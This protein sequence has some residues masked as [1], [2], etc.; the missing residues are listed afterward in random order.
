[1]NPDPPTP[2]RYH[3]QRIL[4]QVGD[5]G[6]QRLRASRVL[7]V[8]CG[9]LGSTVAELLVRG[10]I[11]NLRIVDRDLVELTNLQR[12]LL[13]SERDAREETPKAV[14]AARRLAEINSDVRVEPI[15]ADCNAHNV[16]QLAAW[17]DRPVDLILDGA[18]NVATRYLLNDLAV[19]EKIPWVYGACVGTAGRVMPIWPGQTPCL[20][21]IFPHPPAAH[22]LP[23]CDTSGVLGPA[24]AVVGAWQAAAAMRMLIAQ[25]PIGA[26]MLALDPWHG[27]ARPFAANQ[28]PQPDCLCCGQKN[29]DFLSPSSAEL[30]SSL[31]GRNAVQVQK[32]RQ[33]TFDLDRLSE[34]LQSAGKIERSPW[35]VRCALRDPGTIR[36]T[37]FPDGRLL[38]HGTTDPDRAKSIYARFIGS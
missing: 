19:R 10:G 27:Q 26:G 34:R 3:R 24:A 16:H 32:P 11:G 5:A 25:Q 35:F 13:F 9:A 28:R 8:G 36:L 2:D 38:V 15:V 1:M 21:C 31:C 37:L 7:L 23:T 33:E 6:Q 20:R 17:D 4:P 14:A 30:T 22:E 18:D 12:Q 29:F